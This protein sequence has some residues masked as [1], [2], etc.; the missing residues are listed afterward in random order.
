M[1]LGVSLP[2]SS[3]LWSESVY[4]EPESGQK[5]NHNVGIYLIWLIM[6]KA[7]YLPIPV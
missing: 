3:S 5:H 1:Y 7:V 4:S 6:E 2:L